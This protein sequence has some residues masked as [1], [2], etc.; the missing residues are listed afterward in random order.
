MVQ[1]PGSDRKRK[2]GARVVGPAD[3]IAIT[4]YVRR[5]LNAPPPPSLESDAL[6]LPRHREY[7]THVEAYKIFGAALEDL[8]KVAAFARASP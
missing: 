1:L 3:R 6:K 4:V 2:N 8:D 7:L 5:N